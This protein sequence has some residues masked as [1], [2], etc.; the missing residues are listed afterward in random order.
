M[1]S[2]IIELSED[3]YSFKPIGPTNF[4]IEDNINNEK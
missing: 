3:F 1:I 4:K 2:E